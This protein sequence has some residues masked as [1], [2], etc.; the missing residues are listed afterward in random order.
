MGSPVLAEYD[1]IPDLFV[2]SKAISVISFLASV[3]FD[4]RSRRIVVKG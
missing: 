4:K 3:A 1:F 2:E